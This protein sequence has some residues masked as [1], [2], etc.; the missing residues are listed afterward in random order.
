M[1]VMSHHAEDVIHIGD[2]IKIKIIRCE[3][4]RVK[5]GYDAPKETRILRDKLKQREEREKDRDGL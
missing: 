2:D 1:L 4:G 3:G 5:I